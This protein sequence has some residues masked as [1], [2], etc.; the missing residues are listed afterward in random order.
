MPEET[1]PLKTQLTLI[2]SDV[3]NSPIYSSTLVGVGRIGLQLSLPQ[4]LNTSYSLPVPCNI[5]CHFLAPRGQG[6]LAFR[7]YVMGYER[8]TPPLMVIETPTAIEPF[9]RRAAKRYSVAVPVGYMTNVRGIPG[10]QSVTEDLRS[11]ACA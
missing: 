10:D 9:C 6:L 4:V 2:L 1:L 5:T 8:T 11:A 7:S 3:P